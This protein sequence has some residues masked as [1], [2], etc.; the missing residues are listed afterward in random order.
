MGRTARR[1]RGRGTPAD[2]RELNRWARVSIAAL[3]LAGMA[4]S[5]YLTVLH[6]FETQAWCEVGS[7]CN[8]VQ[9]SAY[10]TIAGVPIA[11]VGLLGYGAILATVLEWFRFRNSGLVLYVMALAAFVFSSY[12]AFLEAFVIQAWCPYCLASYGLVT[13]ILVLLL[14]PRP[15]VRGLPLRRY[16]GLAAG[17]LVTVLV[18]SVLLHWN[19]NESP[20]DE[21]SYFATTLAK[22]LTETGAVM[23]G[24]YLCS[25][26]ASQKALFGDAFRYV[27]YVECHPNGEGA[28]PLLCTQKGI[29]SVPTWEIGGQF[30]LGMRSLEELAQLSGLELAGP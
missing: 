20:V 4:V 8:I 30:Y 18:A 26:C 28:N 9:E 13:G 1:V 2:L 14:A 19:A 23:Y 6:F 17:V 3:A 27:D 12:L 11:L 25:A 16:Q 21:P 10:A 5:G 24:T 29:S 22:H 7:G 15:V